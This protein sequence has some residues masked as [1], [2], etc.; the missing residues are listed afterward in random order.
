[1]NVQ[2]V[3]FFPVPPVKPIAYP[4]PEA[5]AEDKKPMARALTQSHIGRN[6]D[7]KV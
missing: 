2:P 4:R 1:L 6:L 7:L 5:P 3:T